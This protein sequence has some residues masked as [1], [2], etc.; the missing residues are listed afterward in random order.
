MWVFKGASRS[1]METPSGDPFFLSTASTFRRLRANEFALA[2]PDRLH[3]I[4]ATDGTTME[5]LA[6]ESPIKKYPL[7]QLR[8]FNSL[9]PDG[10]PK[11][12]DYIKTVR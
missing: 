1:G 8:L 5:E 10:E 2:E 6:K 3:V 12:G 11:P 4:K 9:Y 7:Q